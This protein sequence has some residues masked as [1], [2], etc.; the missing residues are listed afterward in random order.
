MSRY[1]DADALFEYIQKEKAWKQSTMKN[2]RYDQGKYDAYYEMLKIIK[3]QPTV[4]NGWI[5]VSEKLPE[6][7]QVVLVT[8][9]TGSVGLG[10]CNINS[11]NQWRDGEGY[12]MATEPIAWQPK[13]EGYVV[14]E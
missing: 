2:P 14:E 5:P 9:W 7:K 4:G 8:H 1:I 10:F 12:P 6:N 13:P 3:E 11:G